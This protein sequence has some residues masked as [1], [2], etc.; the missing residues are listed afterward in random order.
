MTSQQRD[1]GWVHFERMLAAEVPHALSI[2]TA[3]AQ[4]NLSV[5][6]PSSHDIGDPDLLFYGVLHQA[7]KQNVLDRFLLVM[8]DL[9]NQPTWPRLKSCRHAQESLIERCIELANLSDDQLCCALHQWTA[10]LLSDPTDDDPLYSLPSQHS[11][12]RA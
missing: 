2:A 7:Y 1:M 3:L 10:Q 12:E 8:H 4:T 9:K 11:P 6:L 5:P